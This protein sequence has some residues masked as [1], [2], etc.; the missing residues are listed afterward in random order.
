MTIAVRASSAA[1]AT[2][3]IRTEM[4][5]L[6]PALPM[7]GVR[8]IDELLDYW[9][10]A[11]RMNMILLD[12]L[13]AL[14][15]ALTLIGIYSVIA[16]FVSQRTREIAIRMAV[17]AS[18]FAVAMMIARRTLWPAVAGLIAGTALAAGL[19]RVI[20]FMLNGISPLEPRAFVVA[21]VGLIATVTIAAL[22]PTRTAM[23]ANPVEALRVE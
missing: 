2:Q 11:T 15:L 23:R 17:G 19:T 16:L 7:F 14:G 13:A 20:S 21:N 3:A 4:R 12:A 6:D 10:S 1:A 9:L 18:G 22:L 8:T 5:A